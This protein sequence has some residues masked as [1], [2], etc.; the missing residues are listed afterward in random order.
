MIKMYASQS[1]GAKLSINKVENC[2][3]YFTKKHKVSHF[4]S[5]CFPGG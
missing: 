1:K 3:D 4:P 2:L 5:L